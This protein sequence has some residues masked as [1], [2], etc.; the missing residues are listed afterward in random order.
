[1]V[2]LDDIT[3]PDEVQVY[4]SNNNLSHETI[5][6]S[7]DLHVKDQLQLSQSQ[8]HSLSKDTMGHSSQSESSGLEEQRQGLLLFLLLSL[9]LF[10]GNSSMLPLNPTPRNEKC[11]SLLYDICSLF[12]K[13]GCFY[14]SH[15]TCAMV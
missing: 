9:G 8:E 6:I 10:T 15:L 1:M 2:L 4:P 14:L 11:I 13:L 5:S 7:S 3:H 12:L